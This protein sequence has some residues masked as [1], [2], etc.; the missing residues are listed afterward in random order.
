[1][2]EI[3]AVV[4][5]EG[6][7]DELALRTLAA[8]RGRDLDAEGVA[9]VA[10]GGATSIGRYVRLYRSAWMNVAISGLCDVGEEPS[11][12]RALEHAGL[13]TDLT[14]DDMEEL[15]FS[16]CDA[17]LEDELIRALGVPA[18][19]RVLAAH[20]DLRAWRTMQ[21]QPAQQDVPV[22]RQL[23]RFMGTKSGRKAKYAPL[24][25]EALELDAIPAPLDAVLARTATRSTA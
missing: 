20:G 1:V 18:V 14:R 22:E 9:V 3:R 17:D 12:R 23:R 11:V 13:G 5:V 15:G 4:L 6:E 25:V 7:S 2:A 16:V 8:R 21:K 10:T 19:E 24:L